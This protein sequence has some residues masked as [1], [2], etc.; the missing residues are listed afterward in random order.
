MFRLLTTIFLLALTLPAQ[1]EMRPYNETPIGDGWSA[2]EWYSDDGTFQF[3]E[4]WMT[5]T[6]HK[7]KAHK[8]NWSFALGDDFFSMKL[9][10]SKGFNPDWIENVV[11]YGMPHE[12]GALK[13]KAT[14]NFDAD[15]AFTDMR[16]LLF[17]K[18]KAMV[19]LNVVGPQRASIMRALMSANIFK[20]TLYDN[21]PDN[22]WISYTTNMNGS[23]KA[24]QHLM[25]CYA[26]SKGLK[27]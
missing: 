26:K 27:G 12:S 7:T 4:I 9:E 25:G 20:A 15:D 18:N 23:N 16:G 1:A 21:S 22:L 2:S 13:F 10:H 19:D 6:L 24:F 8:V 17:S 3:C 14:L 5:T 11:T